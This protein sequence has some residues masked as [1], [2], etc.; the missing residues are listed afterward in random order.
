MTSING[1]LSNRPD[2]PGTSSE[3]SWMTKRGF[4]WFVI[5]L[6]A[7]SAAAY[8]SAMLYTPTLRPMPIR[9]LFA[10]LPLTTYSHFLGGA[11]ALATG[12]LQ[13]G[14][15]LRARFIGL[16]R[17]LRRLYCLAVVVAGVG[18]LMLVQVSPGGVTARMGFGVL[19]VLWVGIPCWRTEKFAGAM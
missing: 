5:T 4:A 3:V 1:N 13:F 18:G 9:A 14:T 16:H 15:R 12:A 8:V 10:A 2:V 17:W 6:F 7:L 11:I 19:A